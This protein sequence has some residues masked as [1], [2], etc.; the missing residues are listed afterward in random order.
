V[1]VGSVAGLIPVPLMSAYAAT[2]WSV[3]GFSESLNA[4]LSGEGVHVGV[5][6]PAI[7]ETP[8]VTR[9]EER[10]GIS[11]PELMTL[12]PETVSSAVL[13]VIQKERDIVV[14]PRALGTIV[15]FHPTLGPLMRWVARESA[16]LMKPRLRAPAPKAG[17][18]RKR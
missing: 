13:E 5:A 11:V 9:E 12:K 1:N 15:A 17:K 2:K 18:R 16:S 3:T 14:V 8:L 10:T 6:C 7:V 4:E